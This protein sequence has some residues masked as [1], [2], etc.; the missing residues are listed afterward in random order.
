MTN[1]KRILLV[2]KFDHPDVTSLKE[3][4][5]AQFSQYPVELMNIKRIVK[6]HPLIMLVNIFYLIK[7]YPLRQLLGYWKVWRR[8]WATT[9]IFKQVKRLVGEHIA[10]G[11]YIFTF[12]THADF[13]ASQ[14]AL[15]NFVYTDT[16]NL[17]NLY[18]PGYSQEKLFSKDWRALEKTVYENAQV[19]FTRSSH[20]QR[21]IIEQY[22]V[23]PHKTALAYAG[24]NTPIREMD[25]A[26]KDYSRKNILFVG[27]TWERKGGPD[28]VQAYK[29]VLHKHPQASLTIV[30]CEPAINLPNVKVVGKV[31]VAEVEQYY[32]QASIFCLPTRLEPFGIVFIE[33]MSFGL[34]LVAPHTGAVSDFVESGKNGYMFSPGDISAMARYLIDLLDDP[35]RCRKLGQVGYH[36]VRERYT[37]RKV[38]EKMKASIL[39]VIQKW[40]AAIEA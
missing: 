36:L 19:T 33:A 18:T 38:G 35:E 9:Y 7:E 12:Q 21:S 13:D 24:C 23:S 1:K 32:K 26:A 2:Y 31:A 11:N 10:K 5:V 3:A 16:T 4:L 15:P 6:S 30:G 27:V 40:E 20:I 25:L 37:W 28:L 8:F 39:P 14:S 22:G 29:Q 34:P 17:A